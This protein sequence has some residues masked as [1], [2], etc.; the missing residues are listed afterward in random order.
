MAAIR[1]LHMIGSLNVGGSQ[2]MILNLY[3]NIDRNLIQFD[4]ILDH[5]END[6]YVDL[7]QSM[8][9]KVY[10]MPALKGTNLFK[11]I[12]AWDDFFKNHKEYTVLHSHIRSYA[13][14]Y[15]PIAK[16]YGLKTII[17]SHSTS[18]GI[19]VR[20]FAK[21]I[22]QY[23]LRYQADH[24]LAC[25]E[26]AGAWLFGEKVVKGNRYYTLKNAIDPETYKW[27]QETRD[28]YRGMLNLGS[29][30]V[31][32][33]VGRLHLAK[34]Q[35][36]LLNVFSAILKKQPNSKLI[37][38]GDGELKTDLEEKITKLDLTR[39][40]FMLGSRDDVA[41]LLQAADCF[42]FPSSWEGLGLGVIEAQAAGLPCICSDRVPRAAAI[43]N[44]CK[45]LSLNDIEQWC[46]KAINMVS[47]RADTTKQIID[48]GYDIKKT[49]EWLTDFYLRIAQ[50]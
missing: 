7:V 29:A 42:L 48:A 44:L 2:A 32:I 35:L 28:Q 25:S 39:D 8:G 16:K 26:I 4:F 12:R 1:V 33:N 14:V 10:S 20:A 50:R 40:V 21:K 30:R 15:I 41:S 22:L 13:S 5:P 11:V 31:Y 36:F 38:V 47:V 49:T 27:N 43:T 37:I 23:P 46:E 3:K 17:H 24:F 45:F 9:A 18:N 19:G 6:Y 34:N